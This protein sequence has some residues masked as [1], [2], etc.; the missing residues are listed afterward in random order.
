M[1]LSCGSFGKDEEGRLISCSQCGQCY[2]TYCA[3][4]NKVRIYLL[5]FNKVIGKKVGCTMLRSI[6]LTSKYGNMVEEM[7]EDSE[8]MGTS[9]SVIQ[10]NYVKH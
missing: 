7:K 4:V 1:C 9:T 6:Y 5:K 2:H 10:S 8:K 3:G